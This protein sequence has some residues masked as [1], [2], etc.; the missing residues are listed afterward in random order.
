MEENRKLKILQTTLWGVT[1]TPEVP[2]VCKWSHWGIPFLTFKV[3]KKRMEIKRKKV[4]SLEIYKTQK[5][6]PLT[7][8]DR[9]E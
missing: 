3:N 9:G 8:L 1:N 6:R 4:E 5:D 2:Y 7:P